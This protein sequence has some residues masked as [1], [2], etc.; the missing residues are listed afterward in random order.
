MLEIVQ[1]NGFLWNCCSTSCVCRITKVPLDVETMFTTFDP[2]K[3]VKQCLESDNRSK[4]VKHRPQSD[5]KIR[6]HS[7]DYCIEEQRHARQNS[8]QGYG[9]K[10]YHAPQI[11]ISITSKRSMK[12]NEDCIPSKRMRRTSGNCVTKDLCGNCCSLP[13]ECTI[14][15]VPSHVG[16]HLSVMFGTSNKE[17]NEKSHVKLG[18]NSASCQLKKY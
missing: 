18:T 13:C 9:D 16:K 5:S 11:N 1:N 12:F 14:I 3:G 8:Q 15:N 6:K 7:H 10:F 17:Q 4:G 2:S